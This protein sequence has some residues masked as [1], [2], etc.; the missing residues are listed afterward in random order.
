MITRLVVLHPAVTSCLAWSSTRWPTPLALAGRGL[1]RSANRVS[2]CVW[3]S[4]TTTST[5]GE[6][7]ELSS[8]APSLLLGG[9]FAGYSA[10]CDPQTGAAKPVPVYLVPA[11]MLEWGQHPKALEVIVSEDASESKLWDRVCL[12]V[13]PETGCGVDNLEVQK[14]TQC[15]WKILQ[16]TSGCVALVRKSTP[17]ATMVETIFRLP[18]DHHRL[19]VAL[20]WEESGLKGIA[21]AYEQ[22]FETTSTQGTRADGGGLDGASLSRWMGPVLAKEGI[23]MLEATAAAA[24]NDDDDETTT[25]CLPANVTVQYGTNGAS[26]FAYVSHANGERMKYEWKTQDSESIQASS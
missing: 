18:A 11:S 12:T 1:S 5:K 25:I 13:L 21:M 14:S 20:T 10:D 24:D 16:E 23:K 4:T 8:D 6:S 3:A 9:D 22:R 26:S 15:G 2:P 7:A 19:R 17:T